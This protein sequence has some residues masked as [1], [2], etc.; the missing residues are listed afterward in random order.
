MF[1]EWILFICRGLTI[2]PGRPGFPVMS[3]W[4]RKA[5]Y[6]LAHPF[7]HQMCV[8]VP[9][10]L[11]FFFSFWKVYVYDCLGTIERLQRYVYAGGV[12]I[13]ISLQNARFSDYLNHSEN[14]DGIKE[15]IILL[16]WIVKNIDFCFKKFASD[17]HVKNKVKHF[18][19]LEYL[20]CW[21][22]AV[23]KQETSILITL[24]PSIVMPLG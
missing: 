19:K 16:Q 8:K 1:S 15:I 20:K 11:N 12:C 23:L 13:K 24:R 14:N 17:N 21:Q 2:D 6:F 9:S 10:S 5:F 22:K 3:L 4:P 18:I 7:F